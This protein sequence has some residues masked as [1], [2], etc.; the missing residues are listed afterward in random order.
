MLA[1]ER[2]ISVS[3]TAVSKSDLPRSDS[4]HESTDRLPDHGVTPSALTL[5]AYFA[6]ANH[7]KQGDDDSRKDHRSRLGATAASVFDSF[8]FRLFE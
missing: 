5:G 3:R 4:L 1:I 2:I 6:N 7:I 8:F